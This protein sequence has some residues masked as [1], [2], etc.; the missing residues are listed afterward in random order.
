VNIE[1]TANG[2]EPVSLT[3]RVFVQIGHLF[4]DAESGIRYEEIEDRS[5]GMIE[6]FR[7]VVREVI[8]GRTVGGLVGPSYRVEGAADETAMRILAGQIQLET[9]DR[10]HLQF[11]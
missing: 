10:V 8:E 7:E 3:G 4:A 11:D 2:Q 6:R 5:Q 9:S 1:P